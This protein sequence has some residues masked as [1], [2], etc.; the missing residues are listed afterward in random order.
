MRTHL[1]VV[2][3]L[4]ILLNAFTLFCGLVMFLLTAVMG[5]IA[6]PVFPIFGAVG[7]VIFLFMA[8]AALPGLIMGWGLLQRA[9]WARILGIVLSILYLVVHPAVGFSQIVAIYTLIVLFQ[10]ETVRILDSP[11]YGTL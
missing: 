9:G 5:I 11:R 8:V 3:W 7:A 10:P 4:N 2:A 6:L 1:T